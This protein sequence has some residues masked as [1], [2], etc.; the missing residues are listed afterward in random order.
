MNPELPASGILELLTDDERS[1]LAGFGEFI[2]VQ[3]KQVLIEEDQEQD[4]LYLVVS[5][6]LEIFTYSGDR[7]LAL[8]SREAGQCVGE[9]NIFDPKDASASVS[10]EEGFS[11]AWRINRSQLESFL[12]EDS[13]AAAKFLIGIAGQLASSVRN[14]NDSVIDAKVP[15]RLALKEL[16]EARE[17]LGSAD[18]EIDRADQVVKKAQA[19]LIQTFGTEA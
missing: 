10:G 3:D 11:Q 14:A 12:N 18:K 7:R 16:T 2:P 17:V 4:S 15:I 8:G 5:G 19:D 6:K 1:I 9:V 13:V